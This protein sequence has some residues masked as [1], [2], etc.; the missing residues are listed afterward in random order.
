MDDEDMDSELVESARAGLPG[1]GAYLVSR[2]APIL[3]GYCHSIAPDLGDVDR[4]FVVGIAI[5][6]ALRKIETYDSNRAPFEIWL[7][8]FVKFAALE[9]RRSHAQTFPVDPTDQ[10]GLLNYG[11]A[12]PQDL[13]APTSDRLA[14]VIAA[15]H[16]ALPQ[17]K[18]PDQVIIGMRD[19]EGRPFKDISA[20]LEI[21]EVA[22]RQRHVRAIARL[23]KLLKADART[24]TLIGEHS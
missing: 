16:A 17:L 12:P 19:L 8:T 22:A 10:N 21:T 3:L 4:E 9:W 1:A 5:E 18:V 6:N 11:A 13:N 7:R 14:S 15:L 24:A 2:Y 20:R 23:M